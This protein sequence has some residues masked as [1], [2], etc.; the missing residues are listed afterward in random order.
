MEIEMLLSF[1]RVPMA[2]YD[3]LL[4]LEP[5]TLPLKVLGV[6]INFAWRIRKLMTQKMTP[7]PDVVLKIYQKTIECCF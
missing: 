3:L 2:S 5:E 4:Q 6:L 7:L 1:V